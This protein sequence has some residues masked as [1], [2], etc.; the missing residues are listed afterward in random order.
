MKKAGLLTAALAFTVAVFAQ[1][2]PQNQHGAKVSATAKSTDGVETKGATV[3]SSASAKSQASLQAR[4]ESKAARAG[5]K[6]ERQQRK[7]ELK[8]EISSTAA[9]GT[10]ELSDL[11]GELKARAKAEKEARKSARKG[12]DLDLPVKAKGKAAVG[13]DV[14]LRRP[15]VRGHINTGAGLGL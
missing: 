12:T 15:R 9:V 11:N 5:R 14:Q 10:N 2:E 1:S 8:G 13:A 7:A 6:A 4:E 3:S